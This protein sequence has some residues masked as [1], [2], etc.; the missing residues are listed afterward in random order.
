MTEEN[1]SSTAT[2]KVLKHT[3]GVLSS[4]WRILQTSMVSNTLHTLGLMFSSDRSYISASTMKWRTRN[5]HSWDLEVFNSFTT[6]DVFRLFAMNIPHRMSSDYLLWTWWHLIELLH[7]SNRC[8][9]C[10]NCRAEKMEQWFS[11]VASS[12]LTKTMYVLE[13][14]S[15][16]QR[17]ASYPLHVSFRNTCDP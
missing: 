11:G 12:T 10:Q 13:L 3:Q 4:C 14:H 2:N 15:N 6:P 16:S 8:L 9:P 7:G 17:L 5:F 1:T